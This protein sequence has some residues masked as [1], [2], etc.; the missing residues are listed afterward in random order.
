MSMLLRCAKT[1]AFSAFCAVGAHAQGG[2]SDV[3]ATLQI[4]KG[5]VMTSTGNEYVSGFSGKT[6]VK[7]E[8]V[9]IAQDG[10]ATITYS[11]GC[12]RDLDTPGVYPVDGVCS[13]GAWSAPA[14]AALVV[15]GAVAVKVIVDNAG[16]NDNTQNPISR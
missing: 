8:R 13:A 10:A 11:N 15:A 7:A 2:D 14:V 9:M 16:N 3:I 1:F 6:L 12:K 4:N 5:V